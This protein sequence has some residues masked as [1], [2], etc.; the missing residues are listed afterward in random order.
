MDDGSKSLSGFHFNTFSFN[1]NEVELLRKAL[2][3]KFNL[4]TTVH[5]HNK[6]LRIYIKAE[7]M[8][9]FRNLVKPYFVPSM[10]YKLY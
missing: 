4:I 5:S 9:N 8:N 2:F 1:D 7:S 3:N 6:G 10:L